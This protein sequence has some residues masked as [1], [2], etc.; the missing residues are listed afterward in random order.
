MVCGACR[1]VNV[2]ITVLYALVAV[3]HLKES[4]RARMRV[5]PLVPCGKR[6]VVSTAQHDDIDHERTSLVGL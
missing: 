5:A 4:V 2:V 1:I 6:Q 3:V